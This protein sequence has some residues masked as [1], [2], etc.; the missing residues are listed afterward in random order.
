MIVVKLQGGLGNQM[1]QYAFG[2]KV[3]E[4]N[5]KKIVLDISDF[6]YDNLRKYSLNNF[7][8]NDKISIDDSGCY[9]KLYDRRTNILI[10][11]GCNLFPNF[12]FKLFQKFGVYIWDFVGYKNFNI[13][14]SKKNIYLHGYWQSDKYFSSISDIIRKEL[15][16]KNKINHDNVELYEKIQSTNSVCVHIR[17]GDFLVAKNKLKVCS[18]EYFSKAMEIMENKVDNHTFFIFS[19]DIKDVKQ[20]FDFSPF[21]VVFVEKKNKD[22]EELRLMYSCKHFIISNSTF[23]WWAQYLSDSEDKIVIAPSEWY[24]DGRAN[25]LL[26]NDWIL[27]EP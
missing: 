3:Q 2:R 27:L 14:S 7:S 24:T 15:K 21:N 4:E 13:D 20:N 8:L 6:E 25:D 10:K 12:C 11:L 5:G 16:V 26:S 9:N 22:Y 23:S 1:F 17:R 19:D 18:N